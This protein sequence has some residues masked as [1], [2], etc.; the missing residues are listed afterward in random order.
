MN[1]SL[2]EFNF[3]LNMYIALQNGTR[4]YPFNP[5]IDIENNL[6]EIVQSMSLMARFTSFMKRFYSTAEH[7]VNVAIAVKKMGGTNDEI[8][9]ALLHDFHEPLCG[10]DIASPYKKFFPHFKECERRNATYVRNYFGLPVE[11]SEIV[12]KADW[13]LFLL[14]DSVLRSYDTEPSP[15]DYSVLKY[16][17]DIGVSGDLI[18]GLKSVEAIGLFMEY[19]NMY[20][21][22]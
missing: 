17:E 12:K 11:N 2:D 9:E 15:F 5:Q 21:K 6:Y 13:A 1:D 14:E 4:H 3:D 18:V 20:V 16:Y 19:Y 10:G 22:N 7:S 8:K